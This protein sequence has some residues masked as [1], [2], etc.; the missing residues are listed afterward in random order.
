[1]CVILRGCIK[2]VITVI[3]GCGLTQKG[4]D[5]YHTVTD[6]ILRVAEE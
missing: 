6:I 5:Y 4:S 2:L 3:D 1:M